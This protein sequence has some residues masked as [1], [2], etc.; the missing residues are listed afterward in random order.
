MSLEARLASVPLKLFD[1]K[2][3]ELVVIGEHG[4][5]TLSIYGQSDGVDSVRMRPMPE[6]VDLKLDTWGVIQLTLSHANPRRA[7]AIWDAGLEKS[8]VCRVPMPQAPS[9]GRQPP[10][11]PAWATK[12]SR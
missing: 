8:G 11:R 9:R 4:C 3:S 1:L 12:E 6:S 10:R 2:A 7:Q 5:F